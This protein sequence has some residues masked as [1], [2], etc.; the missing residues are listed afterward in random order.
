MAQ[1]LASRTIAADGETKDSLPRR[2]RRRKSPANSRNSRS[3]SASAAA[4]GRGLQGAPKIVGPLGGHQDPAAGTG[5]EAK[6]ADRF[7]REAATLAKLNHPNI[8]TIH[9]FGVADSQPSTPDFQP[10]YYIVMEFVDGVNLRDLLRDGKLEPKQALA[11]S[12]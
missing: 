10:L 2:R 1:A 6:F 8:V 4:D 5:G 9:D 7:A 12:A 11:I 3:P